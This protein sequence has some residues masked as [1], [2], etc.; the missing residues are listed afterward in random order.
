MTVVRGCHGFRDL[1]VDEA[2]ADACGLHDA[3][4]MLRKAVLHA[5]EHREVHIDA[6]HAVFL[7]DACED[8][9]AD[10]MQHE[11]VKLVDQTELLGDG[12]EFIREDHAK[13]FVMH[14]QE[15]FRT[16]ELFVHVI[17][18]L[19]VDLEAALLKSSRHGIFNSLMAKDPVKIVIF[20]DAVLDPVGN[21][22]FRDISDLIGRSGILR[23]ADDHDAGGEE[24]VRFFDLPGSF[25]PCF[26]LTGELVRFLS[27]SVENGQCES[28]VTDGV[29]EV[30]LDFGGQKL[31]N[32]IAD[33]LTVDPAGNH[34]VAG[35]VE[36]DAAH[37]DHLD[38]DLVADGRS[39][40]E[41]KSSGIVDL[42]LNVLAV[43]FVFD[44]EHDTRE[45]ERFHQHLN[46]EC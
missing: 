32:S 18:R 27:G 10:L 29:N 5:F 44:E 31:G 41:G 35:F 39:E 33:A 36:V 24:D 37:N 6:V 22:A 45:A 38:G 11:F 8:E 20:Q 34:F 42:Q 21:G 30:P 14:T 46:A 26:D 16:V 15:R 3:A 23:N 9:L 2:L 4:H 25:E 12:D 43:V 19:V 1:E 28:A 17:G 40:V 13:L 7:R